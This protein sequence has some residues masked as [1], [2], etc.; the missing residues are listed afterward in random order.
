MCSRA[1]E[2]WSRRGPSSSLS[3]VAPDV[4]GS[5]PVTHPRF[6]ELILHKISVRFGLARFI[7]DWLS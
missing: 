1:G 3:T 4:A 5:N 2:K 6:F 7:G